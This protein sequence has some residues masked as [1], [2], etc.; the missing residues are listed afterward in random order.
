VHPDGYD[1]WR[2]RDLFTRSAHVGA[3][4]DAVFTGG[5]DWG[6]PPLHPERNRRAG[7]PYTIDTIRHIARHA[8]IVRIDHVM[9]LHRLYWI[10][11]GVE[12][13]EGVYVR[14]PADELTA[15]LTLESERNGCAIVGEDLGTVPRHVRP[16]MARHRLHRSYVAQYEMSE[17][18]ERAL[19]H[20]PPNA[21]A[22]MNTHDMPTFA[23]YW[24][25]HDVD[26]LERIGAMSP[27]AAAHERSVRSRTRGPLIEFL[28]AN[29]HLRSGRAR[30]ADV[31]RACLAYLGSSRAAVVVANLEDLWLETRPQNVPGTGPELGNWRRRAT[32]SLEQMQAAPEV[33]AGLRVLAEARAGR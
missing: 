5:Q 8:G 6:F 19:A 15:I 12:R 22:A 28:R 24:S 32:R 4:P 23:S 9:G 30:T 21:L 29:G 26:L 25:G 33:V 3:P 16:H 14:Y 20:V 27:E 17:K 10:P 11:E 31:L 18:A 2:E 7:H 13:G 1:V